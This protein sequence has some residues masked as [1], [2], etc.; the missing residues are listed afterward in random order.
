MAQHAGADNAAAAA[1]ASCLQ[2]HKMVQHCG[3]SASSSASHGRLSQTLVHVATRA[4]HSSLEIEP[5]PSTSH[6]VG[7]GWGVNGWV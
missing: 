1:A 6:C 5:V 4:K 3:C 2:P 7:T